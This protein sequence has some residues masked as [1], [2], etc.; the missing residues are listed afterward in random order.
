MTLQLFVKILLL[1]LH[2]HRGSLGRHLLLRVMM[3]LLSKRLLLHRRE[4]AKLIDRSQLPYSS[5]DYTAFWLLLLVLLLMLLLLLLRLWV[6][7]RVELAIGRTLKILRVDILRLTVALVH[8]TFHLTLILVGDLGSVVSRIFRVADSDSLRGGRK[9]NT[10]CAAHC[11]PC[12]L[13][14]LVVDK[15]DLL[16]ILR[17]LFALEITCSC[18]WRA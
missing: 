11:I 3:V 15:S 13:F 9:A 1:L 14:T 7:R 8:L 6:V 10:P 2:G 17:G 16:P 12:L 5:L 18:P 4:P